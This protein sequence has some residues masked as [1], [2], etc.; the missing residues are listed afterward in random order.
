[1]TACHPLSRRAVALLAEAHRLGLHVERRG[2]D[3]FV[4][5]GAMP[6]TLD[7]RF[8]AFRAEVLA[9]LDFWESAPVPPRET[10]A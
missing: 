8:R 7:W 1:M 3:T 9:V 4:L 2:A 6:A 10:W 5:S